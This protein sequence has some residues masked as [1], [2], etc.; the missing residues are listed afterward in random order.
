MG[1]FSLYA[2]FL[3]NDFASV[4][5]RNYDSCYKILVILLLEWLLCNREIRMAQ[6]KILKRL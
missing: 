2:G 5:F 4:P 6:K 3:Y 1:V